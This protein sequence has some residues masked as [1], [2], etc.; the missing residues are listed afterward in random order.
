MWK[1]EVMYNNI[2]KSKS[3]EFTLFSKKNNAVLI[4]SD[5]EKKIKPLNTQT[6]DQQSTH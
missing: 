3:L 4:E 1:A 6:T 2:L 5:L